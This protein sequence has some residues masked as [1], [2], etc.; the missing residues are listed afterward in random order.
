MGV[1][2]SDALNAA[3]TFSFVV[4]LIAAGASWLRG[5]KYHY[6]EEE[7]VAESDGRSAV[8]PVWNRDEVVRR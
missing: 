4:C 7:S 6:R 1:P 2:F 8:A 5:G 3:F